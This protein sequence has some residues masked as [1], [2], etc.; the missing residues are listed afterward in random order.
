MDRSSRGR[1]S[2]RSWECDSRPATSSVHLG[3]RDERSAPACLR[4]NKRSRSTYTPRTLDTSLAVALPRMVTTAM[5]RSRRLRRR[6]RRNAR[7]VQNSTARACAR[8]LICQG[9]SGP[10]LS[11]WP[12]WLPRRQTSHRGRRDGI[13]VSEQPYGLPILRSRLRC[14]AEPRN[15]TRLHRR[16]RTRGE[17]ITGSSA[18]LPAPRHDR[19]DAGARS[20]RKRSRAG[21]VT[22][23]VGKEMV[24]LLPDSC[25]VRPVHHADARSQHSDRR[26][27]QVHMC[28]NAQT[29][30]SDCGTLGCVGLVDRPVSRA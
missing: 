24:G 1:E 14:F 23:L 27:C 28:S 4:L 2:D 10:R 25:D 12:P 9:L 5:I 30:V 13:Q 15:R 6:V 22:L 29:R 21:R 19:D 3:T 18:P 26:A 8:P 11:S 16:A 20:P 7:G 17:S